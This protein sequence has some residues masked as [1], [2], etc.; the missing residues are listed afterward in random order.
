MSAHLVLR[1][2][3]RQSVGTRSVTGLPQLRAGRPITAG[4][5]ADFLAESE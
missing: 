1:V 3:R 2:R 5:I 4:E